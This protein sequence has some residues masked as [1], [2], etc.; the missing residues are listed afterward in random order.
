MRPPHLDTELSPAERAEL[1]LAQMTLEEKVGQ[2]CQYVGEAAAARVGG[3]RPGS[4]PRHENAD[5]IVGYAL[6]L[7]EIVEL[8]RSGKVGSFLKVPGARFV[9]YLQGLASESRLGIPLLIGTD[10]IHGHGMDLHAATIFPS[11]I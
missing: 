8:V 4:A 9:D 2:M 11:P 3:D 1:L 7:G 6:G 10:A 5:E